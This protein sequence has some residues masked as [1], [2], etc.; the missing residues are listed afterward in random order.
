[1]PS[2]EQLLE[3]QLPAIKEKLRSRVSATAQSI[4]DDELASVLSDIH[5]ELPRS[6]RFVLRKDKFVSLCLRSKDKLL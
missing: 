4:S 5:G 3:Q 1:M 6:V 2:L